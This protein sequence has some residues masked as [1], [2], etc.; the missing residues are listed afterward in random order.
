V[1]LAG[2]HREVPQLGQVKTMNKFMERKFLPSLMLLMRQST[3]DFDFRFSLTGLFY[4]T[5]FLSYSRSCKGL[6]WD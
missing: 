6:L 4:V 1:G 2:Y 5:S 3:E